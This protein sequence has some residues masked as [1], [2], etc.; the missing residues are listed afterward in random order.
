MES[1]E[2]LVLEELGEHLEAADR[3]AA[4]YARAY[5][6]SLQ[7]GPRVHRPK[8]LHPKLAELVRELA[9][10]CASMGRRGG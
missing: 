2:A 6:R 7:G 1:M 10:D 9:L 5:V 4:A 8:G 3:R